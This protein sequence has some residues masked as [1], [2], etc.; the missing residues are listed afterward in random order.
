MIFKEGISNFNFFLIITKQVP[1]FETV[2]K[3]L[4]IVN[5]LQIKAY[6]I[7]YCI[8]NNEQ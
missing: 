6:V 8:K 1:F 4:L 5:V 3:I 2:A 7:L